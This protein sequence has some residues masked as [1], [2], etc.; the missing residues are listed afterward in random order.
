MITIQTDKKHR[1]NKIIIIAGRNVEFDE[2]GMAEVPERYVESI[3][4]SDPSIILVD[5][6]D[7]KDF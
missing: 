5:D 2:F 1:V 4:N 3:I 7:A 6:E